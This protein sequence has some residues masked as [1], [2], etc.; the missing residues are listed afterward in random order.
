[1]KKKKKPFHFFPPGQVSVFIL[2]YH[3]VSLY[4]LRTHMWQM[5]Q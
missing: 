2:I 4:K 1:M 3:V 5:L